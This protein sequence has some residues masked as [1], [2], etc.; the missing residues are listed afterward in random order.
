VTDIVLYVRDGCG[1]CDEMHAELSP[2][3]VARGAMITCVDVDA[4]PD[5]KR[6]YG[7]RVPV[8]VI[9]GILIAEGVLSPMDLPTRP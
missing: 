2:W 7:Y 8:L 4:N 3:A 9:D 5:L 1:L 6:R